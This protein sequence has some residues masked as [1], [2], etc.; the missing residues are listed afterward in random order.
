MQKKKKLTAGLLNNDFAAETASKKK[1][2]LGQLGHRHRYYQGIDFFCVLLGLWTLNQA[3]Y[4]KY[5]SL[6]FYRNSLE[7]NRDIDRVSILLSQVFTIEAKEFL[8]ANVHSEITIEK[9]HI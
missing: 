3:Q 4:C 6:K 1:T 7:L 5:F 2:F 8:S 9:G